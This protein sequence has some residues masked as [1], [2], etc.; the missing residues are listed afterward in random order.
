MLQS[1]FNPDPVQMKTIIETLIERSY[2]ERDP[3]DK[4]IMK[5]IAWGSL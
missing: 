4:R 3:E 5:Y 2:I 1:R